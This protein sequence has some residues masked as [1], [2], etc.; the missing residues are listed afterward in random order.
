GPVLTV[1]GWTG[2]VTIKNITIYSGTATY[3]GDWSALT[4]QT[5]GSITLDKVQVL[6]AD[7]TVDNATGAILNNNVF[8]GTG[9]VTVTNSLFK[10]NQ[11]DGLA[12]YSPGKIT[13]TKVVGASNGGYGA[14]LYQN[15]T[16]SNALKPTVVT[17]SQ[18]LNNGNAGLNVLS[19]NP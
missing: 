13:L 19:A 9:S 17:S 15:F 8:S 3:G 6:D 7:D 10:N 2:N 4:V 5:A 1:N 18:F 16:S 14:A 12:A 11:S